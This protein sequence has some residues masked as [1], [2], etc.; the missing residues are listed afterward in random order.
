MLA[1][2]HVFFGEVNSYFADKLEVVHKSLIETMVFCGVGEV[3]TQ[4]DKIKMTKNPDFP[5]DYHRRVMGGILKFKP[6]IE[7]YCFDEMDQPIAECHFYELNNKK[8]IN[9][10]FLLQSVYNW[11]SQDLYCA[12]VWR[13]KPTSMCNINAYW[14]E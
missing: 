2:K 3:G 10:K 7:V 13:L 1:E 11:D 4:I 12:Q 9:S 14:H 5:L 6:E 8:D